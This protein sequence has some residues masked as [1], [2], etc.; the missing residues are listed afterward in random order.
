MERIIMHY[1]Q[2]QVLNKL[3]SNLLNTIERKR[4]L[5]KK[6]AFLTLIDVK[7]NT[8]GEFLTTAGLPSYKIMSDELDIMKRNNLIRETETVGYYTLTAK[9]LW[10]VENKKKIINES[11][12][13]DYFDMKFFNPFK[14][15]DQEL[16]D[17]FKIIV[18][19][20]IAARSFSKESPIDLHISETKLDVIKKTIDQSFDL[21]NSLGVINRLKKEDIYGKSGNEHPVSNLIRHTDKLPKQTKH[22]FQTLGD[23]KYYLK[24]YHDNR[25]MESN[26][27]YLFKRIFEGSK[28]S[29][30]DI[31]HI[32][33]YLEKIG[34]TKNIY[35]F[36]NIEKH[37][38]SSIDY[39]E[40][41]K[42][43]L[44]NGC[45]IK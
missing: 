33:R 18:F 30:D 31:E 42:N 8:R 25:M 23:Q 5:K 38:F 6:S 29:I 41:I 26:L 11:E 1:S 39:D 43:A 40:T 13:I 17:R 12:L 36:E 9:G 16:S 20:M 14:Y 34:H 44:L 21:L 19:S 22:I 7:S 35:F 15:A 45:K 37:R 4:K 27:S 28:L 10:S 2:H 32:Q 3:Y 24:I